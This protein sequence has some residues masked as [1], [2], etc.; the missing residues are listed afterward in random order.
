M[1]DASQDPVNFDS[2]LTKGVDGAT[3]LYFVEGATVFRRGSITG[4]TR[5]II[6][7]ATHEEALK[8]LRE[9]RQLLIDL[10]QSDRL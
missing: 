7:F 4:R 10:L 6:A 9:F 3:N 2:Y 5:A 1:I 8:E